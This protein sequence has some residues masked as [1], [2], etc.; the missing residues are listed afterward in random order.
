VWGREDLEGDDADDEPSLG[1]L[2]P[3]AAFVPSAERVAIFDQRRWACGSDD[4]REL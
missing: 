2:G 3:T 4:D 1:S